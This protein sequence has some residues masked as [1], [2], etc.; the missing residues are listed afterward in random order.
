MAI[1]TEMQ[2]NRVTLEKTHCFSSVTG[3]LRSA[4]ARSKAAKPA[5][6]GVSEVSGCLGPAAAAVTMVYKAANFFT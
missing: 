1:V 4:F 5:K 6:P 2:Q 3:V